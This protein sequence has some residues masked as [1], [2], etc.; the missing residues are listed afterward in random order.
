MGG[1][2]GIK[3]QIAPRSDHILIT[4]DSYNDQVENFVSSFFKNLQNFE[5][6]Q[7]KY[8]TIRDQQFSLFL[9]SLYTEPYSRLNKF[10]QC[11]LV[12][13][14]PNVMSYIQMLDELS[15]EKFVELKKK[16]LQHASFQWLIQGHLTEEDAKKI[17]FDAKEAL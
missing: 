4:F 8:E 9:N 7:E 17:V 6:T 2:A 3:S 12:S 13:G 15:Y 11:T 14:D 16:W 1:L 10:L 5:I